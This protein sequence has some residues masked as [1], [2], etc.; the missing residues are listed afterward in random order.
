VPLR[1]LPIT[2]THENV[3]EAA[4]PGCSQ[5]AGDDCGKLGVPALENEVIQVD[6]DLTLRVAATSLN[7]TYGLRNRVD[8]GVVVP[9]VQTEFRGAS[10][11][12]VIPFGG[13]TAVHFF[14]GTPQNPVL[15]ASRE[16]SG[17]AFGV[18]DVAARVKV[19][20]SRSARSGLALLVDAR[21][22]T[23]DADN[24]MGA[25]RFAARGVLVA[26]TRL[27]NTAPHLNLGYLARG[28]G[29]RNDAVL[30][31]IGFDQLI[32]PRVTLAADV[33]S[34]LQVGRNRL[35]LPAPLQYDAPFR[36]TVRSTTIPNVRDDLVNAALGVKVATASKLTGVANLLAPLND[37][38][39]RPRATYTV[40]AEYTF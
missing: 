15:S 5:A 32:A 38:G 8:V 9:F 31:T 1:D 40:G 11:A 24:F 19:D 29:T 36:R 39:L 22:P 13:P 17:S 25:G 18:G 30:T 27:A 6:L 20:L 16:S 33:I 28:G 7:F 23:G 21:L 2:F 34:E 10:R 37:G 14:A 4:S 26:S 3:S 12:Q 35:T